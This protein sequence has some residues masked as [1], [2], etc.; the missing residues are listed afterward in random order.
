M[1]LKQLADALKDGTLTIPEWEAAMR[2]MLRREFTAA[3]ELA[4]G[5][6]ENITQSDWGY[7]GAQLKKQYEFLGN[8]AKDIAANPDKWMSGRL[9]AR[10]SLYGESG[11]G[12]L[13]DFRRREFIE[14]GFD[15]EMRVLGDAEHCPGCLEQS[16]KGWQ[17]IGTLDPIGAEE[18]LTRCKCVFEYRRSAVSL[19]STSI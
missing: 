7:M 10:M 4:K 12:A 16:G 14:Q 19:S 5:G 3:M 8:F 2:D 9:D 6:R 17:P 13:Q 1:D 18:C 11:Y 15:E